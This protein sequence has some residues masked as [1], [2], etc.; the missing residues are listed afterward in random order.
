MGGILTKY[1]RK[2]KMQEQPL[3]ILQDYW[4]D[5]IRYENPVLNYFKKGED[6]MK[7]TTFDKFVYLIDEI[8]SEDA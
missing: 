1:F 8:L 6:Q 2:L 3:T 7:K 5:A 4:N